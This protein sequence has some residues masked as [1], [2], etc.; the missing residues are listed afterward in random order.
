MA[1]IS[2]PTDLDVVVAHKG[3]LRWKIRTHGIAVHSSQPRHGNNAIYSMAK[4]VNCLEK[5][6]ATLES[7][8][9]SHPL[10]GHPT[11]SVGTINGGESVNIVPDHCVIEID[12]RTVP[13]ESVESILLATHQVLA[14]QTHLEFEMLPPD[15]ICPA[16]TDDRNQNLAT[17]L[18]A[19]A[20]EITGTSKIIGV[21]F[22]THAPRFSEAGIPTVVFGP[23]SIRQAHTKDEWIAIDQVRQGSE[24]LYELIKRA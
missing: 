15:T 10:C 22:A 19:T 4:L 8:D 21:S 5:I 11:F 3:V 20:N 1:I 9:L 6:A 17:L 23:G 2:E 12:R 18:V 14:E 13:G 16:L 24:I 7:S